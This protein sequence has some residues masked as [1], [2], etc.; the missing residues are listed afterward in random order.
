M[1]VSWRGYV[2]ATRALDQKGTPTMGIRLQ[3]K[4]AVVTGATSNIGRGIGTAFVARV[5]MLSSVAAAG[6]PAPRLS[7]R[8]ASGRARL[9]R[10]DLDGRGCSPAHAPDGDEGHPGGAMMRGTLAGTSGSSDAP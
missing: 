8:S 9:H 1:Q 2:A 5:H 6:S 10:R 4:T 7:I 3:D